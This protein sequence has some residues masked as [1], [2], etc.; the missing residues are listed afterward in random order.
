[1]SAISGRHRPAVVVEPVPLRH[2]DEQRVL[3]E[4]V[5][6]LAEEE[7]V[8]LRRAEE[9]RHRA[10]VVRAG[11]D[12]HLERESLRLRVVEQPAQPRRVGAREIRLERDEQRLA[13]Q[14]VARWIAVGE[15]VVHQ[16]DAYQ[17]GSG[18]CGDGQQGES[19]TESHPAVRSTTRAVKGGPS[20]GSTWNERPQGPTITRAGFA[21]RASAPGRVALSRPSRLAISLYV[22]PQ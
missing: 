12:G 11:D 18:C 13:D 4:V 7:G 5:V 8:L 20:F 2:D 9:T 21:G 19:K 16:E 3:E 15:G 10:E 17:H 14:I 22:S 6:L 1:H